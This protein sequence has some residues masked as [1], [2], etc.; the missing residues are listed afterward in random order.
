MDVISYYNQLLEK[1]KDGPQSVGWGSKKSQ[2]IR[3]KVL[4]EIG[5]LKNKKILDYGCGLGDFY[6][7][8]QKYK[9]GDYVG[10]D[11]NGKMVKRA[12]KK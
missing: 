9:I 6:K 1:N 7:F 2:N 8:L 11:I 12:M 3:F 5:N 4:A 10:Y